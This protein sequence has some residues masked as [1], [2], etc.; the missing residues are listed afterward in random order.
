MSARLPLID[1]L[2]ALA[3]QA[4]VL[5]HLAFY[6]PMA[7]ALG[8]RAEPLV[9]ALAEHGRLAVQVFLAIG[10]WL[11]ARALAPGGVP[12]PGLAPFGEIGRRVLRLAP[13]YWAAL[14]LA[15]AA[16]AAARA[17]GALPSTPEAPAPLQ[18]LANAAMLQDVLGTGSVTAGAWYVAIDLQLHAVT[19]AIVAIAARA[20]VPGA[21]PALVAA[22]TVASLFVFNR[23][24]DWDPWAPYFLGAYGLGALAAWA[25]GSRRPLAATAALAA[26][27]AAALA[28]D[29]RSRIAVAAATA[30]LLALAVRDPRLMRRPA[31]PVLAA[32][33]RTSFSVFLV[34]YP[35]M[36]VVEAAYAAW[37]PGGPGWAA[38]GLALAWA[39]SLIVG[40]AF[41]RHVERRFGPGRRAPAPAPDR[42]GAATRP[43]PVDARG[44]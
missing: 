28:F 23:L 33:G 2:K 1:A 34:H 3:S 10:G 17:I 29:W 7:Q 5:H 43:D 21:A 19:V 35:V 4:I 9:E 11:T 27:A 16:A 24:P 30:L 15:V 22:G 18:W 42:A 6:G 40:A 38:A 12:A 37:T 31:S 39:L 32:L 25:G 14:A 44:G 20:G 41:H 36:L 8:P 13:P 26:L